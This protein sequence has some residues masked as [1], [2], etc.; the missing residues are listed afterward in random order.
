[1]TEA[2]KYDHLKALA[3]Q[4]GGRFDTATN[5]RNIISLRNQTNT[6]ANG[7]KGVYDDKT[8]VA[9]TDSS[10]RKRVSEYNS[11]T[12]PSSQYTGRQG[13][14]A[15]GD[16]RRDLGR[17]PQGFYEYRVERGHSQFG[18]VL[19]PTRA[20]NAERDTNHDGL[21][22]DNRFAS[23]GQTMLF[24]KG[25]NNNTGSAGCQTMRPADFDRFWRDVT[26]GGNT[27]RIGYTLI[28]VN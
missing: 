2:Q 14:D 22:N 6:K 18:N 7:G 10:G 3:E 25:G 15:N 9:W 23:A 4:N 21:F 5:Q 16:G 27:S 17:L 13:V 19:R 8:Y 28:N 12:E 26:G 11:N 24:H 20:T 1:M